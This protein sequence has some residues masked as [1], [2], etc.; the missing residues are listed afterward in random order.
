M[1]IVRTLVDSFDRKHQTLALLLTVIA[2]LPLLAQ[3]ARR[4]PEEPL[5]GK[6]KPT[7]LPR[8]A[9]AIVRRDVDEKGIAALIHELVG[10]GTR[11]SISS[12]TD[13]KRGIGC[14]R[15]RVAARFRQIAAESGGK[16]QVIV[17][18]F[19]TES[20][21]TAGPVSMENVYAILPGN[22]AKFEKTFLSSPATWTRCRPSGAIPT[23]TR[24]V[25]MTMRL[26]PR[27]AWSAR[28]Y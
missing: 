4:D 9:G 25:R 20:D 7:L 12:W 5:A 18:K 8:P 3:D 23:P 22:D 10:C 1:R 13:P 16:L 15:D 14:A 24:P 28:V 11:L 2:A 19:E 21:R 27:S 17:D 26:E 6:P